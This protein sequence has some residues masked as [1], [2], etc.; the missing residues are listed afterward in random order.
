MNLRLDNI[1]FEENLNDNSFKERENTLS[2]LF[3]GIKYK[4]H[5]VREIYLRAKR[6]GVEIGLRKASLEGQMIEINNTKNPRH[7]EFLTKFHELA[8]DYNCTI[9]YHPEIG[10]VVIDTKSHS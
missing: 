4:Q 5:E 6:I 8:A 3:G 9:Q 7:K 1:L 2:L 10:M